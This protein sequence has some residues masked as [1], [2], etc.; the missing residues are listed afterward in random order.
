MK[1][2]QGKLVSADRG[3]AIRRQTGLSLAGSHRISAGLKTSS[4]CQ[5]NSVQS[6][7]HV[8]LFVIP[9]AAARQASLSFTN[10]R[11]LLKFMSIK[12]VMPSNYLTLCHHLLLPPSIFPSI[13]IFSSESVYW[14]FHFN[15]SPSNEYLGLFRLGL[16]DKQELSQ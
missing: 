3:P 2:T 13:R 10:P 9:W 7:S 4:W 15:M 16:T 12:S 8:Q 11:S 1:K 6:L 5:F 14:S